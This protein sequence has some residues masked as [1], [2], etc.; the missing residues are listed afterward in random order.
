MNKIAFINSFQDLE[1]AWSGT[2]NGLFQALSK[3]TPVEYHHIYKQSNRLAF[4]FHLLTMQLLR[5]H[6]IEEQMNTIDFAE[7]Q[8][9]FTFG[10]YRSKSVKNTY[11]YQD[12]SVDYILR[13]RQ[14]N[15]PAVRFALPRAIPTPVAKLKNRYTK[16]FYQECAGVFT[17][18]EW[19]RRDLIENTGLP[20]EKVH[21]VGGGCNIDV[22]KIDGCMK[23]G[24]RFLFVGKNWEL[25]NGPLVVEAFEKLLFETS[26]QELKLYIAGP[27]VRPADIPE[28]EHII[29]LG[30]LT[31]DELVPYYNMCDYF[32]MPSNFEAYGLVF[33][34]AL[35]FGLPCIANNDQAKPEFI[36]NGKSGI[37]LNDTTVDTLAEAMHKMLTEG[38]TMARY[39][40]EKQK[41]YIEQYSWDSVAKRILQVL[42]A[43]G[44]R[45]P[46]EGTLD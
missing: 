4:I 40:Q 33:A 11:C 18:S 6:Y 46:N 23:H 39:V 20:A 28:N 31:H 26:N 12:L 41:D 7:N 2:P 1:N 37:L 24:N 9:I 30:C 36:Q 5:N 10:E 43:D 19:L 22:S 14:Q 45:N 21:H 25:K 42:Q 38:S 3:Y 34:E 29:Y 27:S 13:L 15:H 32:V 17:M 44:Y 8:P 35:C 16:R